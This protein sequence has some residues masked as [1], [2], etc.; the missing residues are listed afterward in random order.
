MEGGSESAKLFLSL[1]HLITQINQGRKV[2]FDVYY[3][4][5]VS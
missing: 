3:S 1:S 2:D 5:I 4:R